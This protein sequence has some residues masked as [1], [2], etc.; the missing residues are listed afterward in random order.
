MQPYKLPSIIPPPETIQGISSKETVTR[1]NSH[2][3]GL[4]IASSVRNKSSNQIIRGELDEIGPAQN[5]QNFYMSQYSRT[6]AD[7]QDTIHRTPTKVTIPTLCSA[8]DF[9]SDATFRLDFASTSCRS[10]SQLRFALSKLES[11]RSSTTT[12]IADLLPCS[13]YPLR[14]FGGLIRRAN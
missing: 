13:R 2:T 12:H 8:L 14:P 4:S 9:L 11:R 5:P 1:R 6:D 10:H 3:N 7:L